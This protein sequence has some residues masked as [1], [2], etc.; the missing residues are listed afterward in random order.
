MVELNQM[1]K[2]KKIR[3]YIILFFTLVLS[4][5]DYE[6]P[7]RLMTALNIL[8]ASESKED[9]IIDLKEVYD[10]EWDLLYIFKE[11][12]EPENINEIIGFDCQCQ[13]VP[14]SLELYIFIKK[15]AIVEKNLVETTGYD[16]NILN[17]LDLDRSIVVD[18]KKSKFK[19]QKENDYY[20]LFPIESTG[21]GSRSN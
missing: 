18:S 3:I 20:L 6:S 7:S 2:K 15:G 4:C 19:V 17:Y 10:F 1:K 14:D 8:E 12:V 13:I 9:R 11:F 5:Q 16:F 21:N